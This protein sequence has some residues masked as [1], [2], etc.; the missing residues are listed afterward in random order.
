MSVT[1]A[2]EVVLGKHSVYTHFPKVWICEIRQKTKITRS[3]CKK[4]TSKAIPRAKVFGDLIAADHKFS[5]KV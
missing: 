5:V 2:K 1:A 4:R 3:P